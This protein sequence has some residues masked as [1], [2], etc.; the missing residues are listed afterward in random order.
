MGFI[1]SKGHIQMDPAKTQAVRDWP[2]PTSTKQVQRF[3]GFSYF[4][5]KLIWNFSAIAAPLTAF[6]RKNVKGFQW[7]EE[8]EK[9]FCKYKGRYRLFQRLATLYHCQNFLQL[10]KPLRLYCSMSLDC[11]VFPKM[12]YQTVVLSLHPGYGR[13]SAIW[14]GLQPVYHLGFIPSL[15]D[16]Q[17]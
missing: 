5:W 11:M 2:Q 9:A 1:L 17:K 8:A 3:L 4:Y 13:H 14:L 6:T 15:M 16:R 10:H 7:T 12:L